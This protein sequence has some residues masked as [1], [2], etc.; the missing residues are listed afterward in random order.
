MSLSSDLS[1]VFQPILA[2]FHQSLSQHLR[3]HH[4]SVDQLNLTEFTNIF[5]GMCMPTTTSSTAKE[6]LEFEEKPIVKRVKNNKKAST[7]EL[8]KIQSFDFVNEM[9]KD[10]LN[11]EFDAFWN[12]RQVYDE[13]NWSLHTPTNLVLSFEK[14]YPSLEKWINPATNLAV[15]FSKIP[16]HIKQWAEGCNIYVRKDDYKLLSERFQELSR[17]AKARK[18]RASERHIHYISS[19]E[20]E[21]DFEE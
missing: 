21:D 13:N 8:T 9:H 7:E 2:T 10:I 6:S 18:A 15:E 14:V 5:D 17:H 19:S 16:K 1:Q 20:D 12:Q 11:D 3:T 4:L